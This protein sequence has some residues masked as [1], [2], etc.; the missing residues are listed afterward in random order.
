[1]TE[2]QQR[3]LN[4]LETLLH[5]AEDYNDRLVKEME[6]IAKASRRAGRTKDERDDLQ[7]MAED[8]GETATTGSMNGATA[9]RTLL[10]RS[11]EMIDNPKE[12]S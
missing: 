9:L 8:A 4:R 1:M 6:S 2:K 7:M 3:Y 11:K 5:K 12:T 10:H